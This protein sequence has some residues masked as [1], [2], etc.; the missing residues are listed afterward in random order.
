[1]LDRELVRAVFGLVLISQAAVLTLIA[2]SLR[3]GA[4]PIYPLG[5]GA[6]SDPL[7]QALAL[8]A[9]V[10]GLAVTALVLALAVR[11]VH[12]FRADGLDELAAEEAERDARTESAEG[13]AHE[14]EEQAAR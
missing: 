8:T 5:T 11:V 12:A 10:I 7:S 9:I 6:V 13:P 4:A 14:A 1:M 2:S 3:R